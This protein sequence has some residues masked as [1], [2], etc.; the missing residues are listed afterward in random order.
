MMRTE[1]PTLRRPI[2]LAAAVAGGVVLL[3]CVCAPFVPVGEPASAIA[4]GAGYGAFLGWFAAGLALAVR[5][6]AAR[7]WLMSV[8]LP[9]APVGAWFLLFRREPEA[10]LRA[11]WA[12]WLLG[13]GQFLMLAWL[14]AGCGVAAF[15]WWTWFRDGAEAKAGA[16][17]RDV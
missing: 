5:F 17:A 13:V 6:P 16:G 14:V 2:R 1:G 4:F 7:W 15:G 3:F 11:W 9:L 12:W 10:V 8:P